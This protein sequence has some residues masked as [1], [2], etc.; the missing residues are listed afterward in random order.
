MAD[1]RVDYQLLASISRTLSGLAAEFAHAD[2]HDGG[3][4]QAYGSVAIAAAVD[5]FAGHWS[6]QRKTLLGT[7]ESLGQLTAAAEQRFR[8]ADSPPDSPPG[9]GPASG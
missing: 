6:D 3:H 4:D 8:L 5:A 1:L 7:V 2:G 9:T